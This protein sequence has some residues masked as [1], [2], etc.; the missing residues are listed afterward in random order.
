MDSQIV[1]LLQQVLIFKEVLLLG[2]KV[3]PLKVSFY[4][5]SNSAAV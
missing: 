4:G 3:L 1:L 2:T 5:Q